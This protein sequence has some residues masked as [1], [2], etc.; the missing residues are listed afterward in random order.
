MMMTYEQLRS[1][2]H[3]T[4]YILRSMTTSKVRHAICLEII[5]DVLQTYILMKPYT[6]NNDITFR[7]NQ[8]LLI[9]YYNVLY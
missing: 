9:L 5:Y 6:L 1:V 3:C 4:T 2:K 8:L 7:S